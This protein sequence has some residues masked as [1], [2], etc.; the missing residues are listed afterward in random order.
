MVDRYVSFSST[1]KKELHISVPCELVDSFREYAKAQDLRPNEL[2]TYVIC[3]VV[4]EDPR[5]FGLHPWTNVAKQD[6]NEESFIVVA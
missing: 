3:H 4:K 5:K 1:K 2:M 6:D